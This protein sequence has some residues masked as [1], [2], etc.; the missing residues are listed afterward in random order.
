MV[1]NFNKIINQVFLLIT[2]LIHDFIIAKSFYIVKGIPILTPYKWGG[3]EKDSWNFQQLLDLGFSETSQNVSS[4]KVRSS[5][6]PLAYFSRYFHFW[7]NFCH[8]CWKMTTFFARNEYMG[9][10]CMRTIT[11][12]SFKQLFFHSYQGGTKGKSLK[13]NL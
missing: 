12:T 2:Q 5:Y 3:F 13:T 11:W 4:F 7:Q 6:G 9:K 1:R 10:I 8:F